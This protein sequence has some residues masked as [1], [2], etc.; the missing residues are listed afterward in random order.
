MKEILFVLLLVLIDNAYTFLPKTYDAS[1]V[2]LKATGSEVVDFGNIRFLGREKRANGTLEI[3]ED[4]D[5]TFSVSAESFIDSSGGGDYKAL[6]F[7]IPLEPFCKGMNSYWSYFDASLKYGENTDLP[8]DTRPCPIP[9]GV[10]Y[11]KDALIKTDGWPTVMPRGFLKGV[12]KLFRNGE[13]V[14][15]LEVVLHI[16]DLG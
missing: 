13:S 14:G 8:V 12:A 7:S 16:T 9:K 2:S 4:M 15:A 11:L 6:P 5:N 1:F 3:M 10:Y